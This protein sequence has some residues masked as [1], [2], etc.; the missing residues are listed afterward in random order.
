[1]AVQKDA[2]TP[3]A[4]PDGPS[5]IAHASIAQRPA[6]AVGSPVRKRENVLC[7]GLWRFSGVVNRAGRR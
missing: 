2:V 6:Q 4:P 3:L 1:M 7:V 5:Q